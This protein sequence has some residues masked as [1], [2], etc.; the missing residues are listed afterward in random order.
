MSSC[1]PSVH[2]ASPDL[3]FRDA[4]LLLWGRLLVF[5]SWWKVVH[6]L[7]TGASEF[8]YNF[9]MDVVD[10]DEGGRKLDVSYF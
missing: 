6:I 5:H 8:I 10:F 4:I 3:L 7:L 2:L 1:T 9:A